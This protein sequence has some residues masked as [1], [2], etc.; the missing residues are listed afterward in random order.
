MNK[1]K[2]LIVIILAVLA[3][4][5]LCICLYLHDDKQAVSSNY[6]PEKF[7]KRLEKAIAEYEI[8]T[9]YQM[10]APEVLDPLKPIPE[11]RFVKNKKENIYYNPS[12]K[13]SEKAT[14]LFVGDI[15]NRQEQQQAAMKKY[16]EFDFQDM[17]VHIKKT[18]SDCDLLA[19]N[20]ETTICESAKYTYDCNRRYHGLNRNAPSTMLD[21]VRAAGFDFVSTAN[22]HSF[23]AGVT[24]VYQ[25]IYHL[26]QYKLMYVGTF[27][28]KSNREKNRYRMIDINGIKVAFVSYTYGPGDKGKIVNEDKQKYLCNKY[29]RRIMENDV[30]M[31]KKAGAEFVIAYTHWGTEY[32]HGIDK[33][34]KKQAKEMAN[35]GVDF[36]AGSHPHVLEPFDYV[37]SDKGKKVPV[38]Y[39]MGNFISSMDTPEKRDG[40][41]MRLNIE[42]SKGKVK[43]KDISYIPCHTCLSY[44]GREYTTVPLSD[45]NCSKKKSFVEARKRISK[46]IGNKI[47]AKP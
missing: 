18:F 41:V 14:I 29:T 1:K 10:T 23:D 34:Q 31:A 24:G 16:G 3:A 4:F 45:E 28:D 42:K 33:E 11:P 27:L 39:S 22:N 15:M 8:K 12:A 25:T 5:L 7:Q 21:S 6:H 19:G 46:V 35:A 20:L 38:I 43:I 44:K 36:I 30:A 47:K 9:P 26:K 13:K 40:I 2:F 17:F 37:K 32:S